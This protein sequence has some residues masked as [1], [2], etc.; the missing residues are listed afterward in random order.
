MYFIIFYFFKQG[1]TS[2]KH[3]LRNLSL[4]FCSVFNKSQNKSEN[5]DTTK[6]NSENFW[7]AF[8]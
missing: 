3:Y 6:S 2:S 7:S 8:D 4:M 5:S 1:N